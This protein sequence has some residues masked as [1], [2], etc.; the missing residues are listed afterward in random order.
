MGERRRKEKKRS[1]EKQFSPLDSLRFPRRG[2][3]GR[4][5]QY[6]WMK[7]ESTV[8]S[9]KKGKFPPS[10]LSPLAFKKDIAAGIWSG[11]GWKVY[12]EKRRKR[13]RRNLYRKMPKKKSVQLD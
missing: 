9:D 11:D 10:F 3:E 2:G 8:V 5:E 1:S 12:I 7:L 6:S 13:E 4:K